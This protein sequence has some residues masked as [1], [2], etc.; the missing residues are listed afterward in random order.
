MKIVTALVFLHS[1]M[2]NILSLVVPN[3]S[4]LT[5]PACPNFSEDNSENLGTILPPVAIAI[6]YKK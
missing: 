1:S 5:I 6:N 4:S 2:T 3:V